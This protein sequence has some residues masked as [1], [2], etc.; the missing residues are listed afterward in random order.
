M[1]GMIYMCCQ[2]QVMLLQLLY[3]SFIKAKSMQPSN[4]LDGVGHFLSQV[5]IMSN[6]VQC[7]CKVHIT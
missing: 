1:K 5:Y 2:T 6:A 4:P 3:K 7:D